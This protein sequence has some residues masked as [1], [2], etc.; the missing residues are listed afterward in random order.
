MIHI[1]F[2][3]KTDKSYRCLT[4]VFECHGTVPN[5]LHF[6]YERNGRWLSIIL[7]T[8]FKSNGLDTFEAWSS[9]MQAA[10]VGRIEVT[11]DEVIDVYDA[12]RAKKILRTQ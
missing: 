12:F 2:I 8:D 3:R 7:G 4:L 6:W 5:N 11:K 1:E 10:G 9:D